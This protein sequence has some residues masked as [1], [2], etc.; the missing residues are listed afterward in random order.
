MAA[1]ANQPI[2]IRVYDDAQIEG[3]ESFTLNYVVSGATDAIAAP[4]SSSYTFYIGD[5]ANDALPT[6]TTYNG[7]FQ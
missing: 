7:A 6:A 3:T 1:T 5:G 4:S 2:T